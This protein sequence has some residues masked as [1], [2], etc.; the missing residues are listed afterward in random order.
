[1]RGWSLAARKRDESW[2]DF[3]EWCLSDAR[4]ALHGEAAAI[5]DQIPANMH[6]PLRYNLTFASEQE[7]VDRHPD[8]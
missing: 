3:V 5:D 8:H 7:Y 2:T 4:S 1:V 6:N